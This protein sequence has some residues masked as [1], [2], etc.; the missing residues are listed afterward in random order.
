MCS[1]VPILI[2]EPFSRF[3]WIG[4][5]L[6]WVAAFFV[7]K[8]MWRKWTVGRALWTAILCTCA[9]LITYFNTATLY[10]HHALGPAAEP[11]ITEFR[12]LDVLQRSEG[13]KVAYGHVFPLA[14]PPRGSKER[15]DPVTPQLDFD[16]YDKLPA[17][18]RTSS[19]A[20]EIQ[21]VVL[22]DWWWNESGVYE[23]QV[24]G[25]RGRAY[26]GKCT[27]TVIDRQ[28]KKIIA[29]T[30]LVSSQKP[31]PKKRT[32]INWYG[33]QPSYDEVVNYLKSLPKQ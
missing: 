20:E 1:G 28:T 5:L 14:R 21:T 13:G 33:S 11:L 26:I 4:P 3:L 27:I 30:T 8:N 15:A 6:G 9:A 10:T 22:V 24:T 2:F 25:G 7:V 32:A 31:P 18:M 19:P 12:S 16:L 29:E 17:E 23:N